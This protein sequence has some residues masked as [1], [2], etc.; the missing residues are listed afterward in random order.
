MGDNDL[1][2]A[3]AAKEEADGGV[4][5]EL[6][7][8]DDRTGGLRARG[9]MA[10]VLRAVATLAR[11]SVYTSVAVSLRSSLGSVNGDLSS[12]CGDEET[13]TVMP[14]LWILP[15]VMLI[16]MDGEAAAMRL[17]RL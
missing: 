7:S 13:C 6:V 10:T 1:G 9:C 5:P 4:V 12:D 15:V 3:I 8:G 17:T 11:R 14:R 2:Y 16:P